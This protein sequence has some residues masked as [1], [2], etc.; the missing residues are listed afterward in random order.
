VEPFYDEISFIGLFP[1]VE[2]DVAQQLN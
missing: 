2:A 1:E